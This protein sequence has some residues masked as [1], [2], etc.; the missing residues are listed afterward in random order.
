MSTIQIRAREPTDIPALHALIPLIHATTG[1]PVEGSAVPASFLTPTSTLAAYVAVLTTP[2]TTTPLGQAALHPINPAST[3]FAALQSHHPAARA[4]DYVV[5]G[6]LF[7]APFAQGQGVGRRLVC[8]AVERARA[9]G[10][11]VVLDVLEKD[12]AAVRF[13]ERL[14]WRRLGVEGVYFPWAREGR[15]GEVGFREFYY[16]A[17]ERPG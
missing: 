14:G 11:G 13:Y 3:L 2:Q 7:I 16:L 10:R 17:A 12:G 5:L 4:E 1:Y 9:W 15:E 8:E 6:R